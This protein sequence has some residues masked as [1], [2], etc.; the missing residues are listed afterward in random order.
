MEFRVLRHCGGVCLPQ[1]PCHQY[2]D[3]FVFAVTPGARL[4]QHP[5]VL[6]HVWWGAQTCM[7]P[8]TDLLHN[9]YRWGMQ[10]AVQGLGAVAD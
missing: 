8:V 5:P 2:L 9:E 7:F 4:I 1:E 10:V 3:R 6:H